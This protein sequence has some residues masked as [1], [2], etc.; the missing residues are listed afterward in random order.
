MK[1]SSV[2]MISGRIER[3][4]LTDLANLQNDRVAR[5]RKTWDRFYAGVSDNELLTRRDELRL[6]W[7]P[8]F[9]SVNQLLEHLESAKPTVA[10]RSKA[11]RD[12]ADH[13]PA[14][15]IEKVVCEYWLAQARDPWI[16]RWDELKAVRANPRCLAAVLALAC[17]HHAD[18]FGSCRNPGC[19]APYF[20]ARRHDQR[21]CSSVCAGP[22]KRAAKLRW[23]HKC[24]RNKFKPGK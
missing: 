18:R 11:L 6:V 12:F 23:W 15:P 3:L 24:K 8:R 9:G 14:E 20:F 10:D 4:L 2:K 21:Y 1:S 17:I 19:P 5:F 7:R 22:A 16:V 13:H